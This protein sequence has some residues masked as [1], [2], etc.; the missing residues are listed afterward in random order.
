MLLQV[1][2]M[3]LR[4]DRAKRNADCAGHAHYFRFTT[5]LLPLS[6]RTKPVLGAALGGNGFTAAGFDDPIA[7]NCE[8]AT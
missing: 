4:I 8:T 5:T 1:K 2:V 7:P 3:A 6:A